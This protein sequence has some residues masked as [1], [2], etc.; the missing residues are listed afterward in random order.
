MKHPKIIPGRQ[1]LPPSSNVPWS[2]RAER[3]YR[4]NVLIN[5]LTM[6]FVIGMMIFDWIAKRNFW[7]GVVAEALMTVVVLFVFSVLQKNRQTLYAMLLNKPRTPEGL[8]QWIEHPWTYDPDPDALRF[9]CRCG[10]LMDMN[11]AP[12][13]KE[14]KRWSMV[15]ECGRGHFIVLK[16]QVRG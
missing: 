9:L 4:R 2:A 11:A 10:R 3:I 14:T 6:W 13:F 5:F 16:T 7:P 15:C 8:T 12:F 1:G